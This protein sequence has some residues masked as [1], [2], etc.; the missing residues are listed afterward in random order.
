MIE[1]VLYERN[2][3]DEHLGGVWHDFKHFLT[4]SNTELLEKSYNLIC[5]YNEDIDLSLELANIVNDDSLD[6]F[7]KQTIFM[8]Y[9]IS[10]LLMSLRESGIILDDEQLELND[11]PYLI[12]LAVIALE[13]EA[14]N[15]IDD[16]L[17]ILNDLDR[18]NKERIILLYQQKYNIFDD[19]DDETYF[20]EKNILDV[21]DDY[22]QGLIEIING[23]INI[24][25]DGQEIETKERL[26][27]IEERI[28]K[29][30]SIF[31]GS[32]AWEH[33]TN[34]G[35]LGLSIIDLSNIFRDE[36]ERLQRTNYELY[37]R[38][39][40]RL[41]LI[42]DLT[43]EDIV[44][45]ITKDIDQFTDIGDQIKYNKILK[46]CKDMLGVVDDKS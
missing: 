32:M 37:L 10:N 25:D 18:D 31:T 13:I 20:L 33:V 3:L 5:I 8:H 22:I 40:F 19:W 9:M 28:L 21:A 35:G 36:L 7:N 29:N 27:Y 44:N 24:D 43:N 39:S 30:K 23:S 1:G 42:S 4:D 17:S 26:Q 16:F 41:C 46:E 38:E 15:T 11:L 45:Y 2:L 12:R 6:I 14:P 34:D